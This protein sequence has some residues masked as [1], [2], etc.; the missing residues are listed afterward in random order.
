MREG[1]AP[2]FQ[3]NR[4]KKKK[5]KT[6][7]FQE[8]DS[9]LSQIDPRAAAFASGNSAFPPDWDVAEPPTQHTLGT[10]RG[11]QIRPE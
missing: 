10:Y 3:G 9:C 8:E 11:R 1:R 5:K 7:S 2:Q 6:V 4:G